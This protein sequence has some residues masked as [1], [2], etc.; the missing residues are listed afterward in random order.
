MRDDEVL[1]EVAALTGA[2]LD[3]CLAVLRWESDRRRAAASV[4]RAP[5]VNMFDSLSVRVAATRRDVP[6][7]AY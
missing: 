7:V 5:V 4:A 1:A 3:D 2:E 6:N